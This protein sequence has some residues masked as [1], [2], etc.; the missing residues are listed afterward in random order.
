V[1]FFTKLDLKLGYHLIRLRKDNIPKIDFRT[2]DGHYKFSVMPFGL[3]NPPSNFQSLINKKFQLHLRKFVLVFFDYMLIYRKS[4]E[5]HIKHVDQFLQ[6]LENNQLYVKRSKCSFGKQ[7]VDY[8][9]HIVS[10][11]G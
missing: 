6:I 4:W 3:T 11:R 5:Y 10:R 9:G 2:H 8:L 1:V 7:E